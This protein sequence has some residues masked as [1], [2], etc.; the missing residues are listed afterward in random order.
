MRDKEKQKQRQREHYERNKDK[1]KTCLNDRRQK[2]AEWMRNLKSTMQCQQCGCDQG[3]CLEFHHEDEKFMGIAN[4]V[5]QA[6]SEN[7]I[8]EEISK[9]TILCAN[10]HRKH[11]S[12][13]VRINGNSA[14]AK[15][16]L[17]TKEWFIEIKK[18]SRCVKCGEND[19]AC[20]DFHHLNSNEKIADISYMIAYNYG[21]NRIL[22]EMKK[23]EVMCANCHRC[24]HR[25]FIL[26]E[27]RNKGACQ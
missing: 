13:D 20:L 5:N 15:K 4:M 22:E 1:Y 11:H 3:L 12:R 19:P 23:C 2:R 27:K 21:K 25:E 17:E 6:Y 24:L 26:L 7:K 18:L 16:R 9:C 10:C 14:V 8:L